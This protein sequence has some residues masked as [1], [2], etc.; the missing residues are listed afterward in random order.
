MITGEG[1]LF[2]LVS[3]GTS[4]VLRVDGSGH[5]LCDYFGPRIFLT[6]D[7]KALRAKWPFAPGSSVVYDEKKYP[8]TS[9]DVLPLE[10]ATI[11]KGDY[12]EPSLSVACEDGYVLDFLYERSEIKEPEPLPGLPGPHGGEKELAVTLRDEVAG[13]ELTLLYVTFPDAG[14]IARSLILRNVSSRTVSIERIM[15]L[16]LDLPAGDYE[17]MNL[18]GGW[19]DEANKIVRPLVP[20]AY[21]SE[22]RTG[23]SSNRRNPFFI[24]KEKGADYRRGRCYGFNLI[25]SGNH[26]EYVGVSR[27]GDLR[28]QSGISPFCFRWALEPGGSFCAPW[29]VLGV[30][31]DGL[32]GL[33]RNMHR[34]VNGHVVPENFRGKPRPVIVNS[35][36]AT[37]FKFDEAKLLRIARKAKEAGMEL[38]VLDDGWFKGRNDD[39]HALGDYEVDRHKLPHG[40][41]GLARKLAALGLSFGLWFEPESVSPDSDLYKAHPEWA[42]RAP[43]RE[44]ALGRHQL[45]LDLTRPEVVDYIVENVAKVLRSAP[46]SFVKWDMN[47]HISDMPAGK[48]RPGEFFHRYVL[49]LYAALER[50][51]RMFPDV[52]F[53]GS[54]SGGNRFDLGMLSYFPE[55]WASDDTDAYQRLVIQSG[56]ALGYPLSTISNHV[57]A[58][59]SHQTLRRLPLSTRFNVAAFGVLGYELD[60]GELGALEL[61]RIKEDVAWYKERRLL[62]QYGDFSQYADVLKDGHA[63]WAVKKGDEAV[64]GW[65]N[66]LQST[67]PRAAFF[68]GEGYEEEGLYSI[69]VREE[70]HDLR[71]FGGL[72]NM[73]SPVHLNPEGFLLREIAKRRRFPGE[74]ESYVASGSMINNGAVRLDPEWMATGL[75]E[76]VRVLADFGSRLYVVK[77]LKQD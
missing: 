69:D 46:I 57:S 28:I 7:E 10:V 49:G 48:K 14:T 8:G 29:C 25:Y 64:V 24:V 75:D 40:L 4:Y 47:R 31:P 18:A 74:K 13:L 63:A 52:L 42:L 35:W 22:S 3:G 26:Q 20:G 36:E 12:R 56:L 55:I 37:Y 33:A 53:E 38:F 77:K 5:L 51:T 9:L 65:F 6:D 39:L 66:G 15:S 45:L 61:K 43:G 1:K 21:L 41:S 2:H 23:S 11:G 50:L 16:Q 19:V 27:L 71:L 67:H 62:F 34:F 44:P 59:V 68:P 32:N 60:L 73:V 76:N 72:I 70:S 30:S 54:S 58:S 17:L